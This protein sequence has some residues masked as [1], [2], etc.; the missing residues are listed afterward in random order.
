MVYKNCIG[1]YLHG[2]L[3]PKNPHLADHLILKALN[4]KY[5][6]KELQLLDDGLE[7]SAHRRVLKLYSPLK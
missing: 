2:P 7:Y 4:R 5:G 1:T 3:L 6:L